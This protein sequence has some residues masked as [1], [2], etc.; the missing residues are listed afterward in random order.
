MMMMVHCAWA[1]KPLS[2]SSSQTMKRSLGSFSDLC[3]SALV[4]NDHPKLNNTPLCSPDN[5]TKFQSL[6]GACQWMISLVYFN[7]AKPI[8][9]LSHFHHCPHVSHLDSLKHLC[10][11][12]CKFPH[13]AIHFHTSIPP[14]EEYCGTKPAYHDWMDAIYGL[15]SEEIPPHTLNTH[16]LNTHTH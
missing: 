2:N 4:K 8:M 15:V 16:T 3:F 14:H 5:V 1:H 6:L 13:R 10:G 7:L 12:I 9:S 11:Y